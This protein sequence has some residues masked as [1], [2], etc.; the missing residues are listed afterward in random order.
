MRPTHS[1]SKAGLQKERVR[2]VRATRESGILIPAGGVLF[3]SN[4]AAL[5]KVLRRHLQCNAA[6]EIA[7]WGRQEAVGDLLSKIEVMIDADMFSNSIV[8][9]CI[10]QVSL[11][12]SD[13]LQEFGDISRLDL[14]TI[15]MPSLFDTS[16]FQ[17]FGTKIAALFASSFRVVLMLDADNLPLINPSRLLEP[18]T[19]GTHRNIFWPDFFQRH[20][21]GIVPEEVYH[22]FNLIPP[23]KADPDWYH[24]ESG[25]FVI[26]R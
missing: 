17:G 8:A 2:S 23:W 25:Q 11:G 24:T 22:L 18:A 20:G 5:V 16:K 10:S 1:H 4:A 15:R 26:D 14:H 19:L 9:I 13:C 21:L 7:Y 6:I 12:A 3:L